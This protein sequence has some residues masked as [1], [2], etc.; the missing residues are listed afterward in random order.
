[1]V[2]EIR[3]SAEFTLNINGLQELARKGDRRAENE[4][5]EA[6]TARFRLLLERKVVD[7]ND[8]EDLVQESL[9]VICE[10]YRTIDFNISF[11]AWAYKV[12]DNKLLH[13]YR[14]K[15]QADISLVSVMREVDK[16][17][18]VVPDPTLD[19]RL[20]ECLR[21][22]EEAHPRFAR[23]LDLHYQGYAV[24]EICEQLK[25]GRANL[26]SLLSRARSMLR[27]CLKTGEVE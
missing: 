24:H 13:Y 21:K 2:K 27:N 7:R 11:S 8:I 12:L 25:I 16:I 6:L 9:K 17:A 3:P 26:Y 14:A 15:G 20:Q 1:M 22:L 19:L 10:K 5:F 18:V 4:L 23:V